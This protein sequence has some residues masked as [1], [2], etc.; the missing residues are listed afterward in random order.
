MTEL[1]PDSPSPPPQTRLTLV[2]TVHRDPQGRAKLLRLLEELRPDL[3]TLEMSP[4]ALHYRQLHSRHLG[5]RLERILER[6]ARERGEDRRSVAGHP[7]VADILSLLELPFEYQACAAWAEQSGTPLRLIDLGEISVAK[8]KRVETELI[9]YRNLRVLVGL[10]EGA[11]KTSGEGLGFARL[12]LGERL[13]EA[14]RQA[15]LE[16]HRGEEG[17]GQRDK[18]MEG[19]IRELLRSRPGGH[20]VHVGGWLHLVADRRAE[21]LYSRLADLAPQRLLL[22]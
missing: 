10:P 16:R 17:I 11:E 21:T 12:L 6:L 15:F 3:L 18:W 1:N 20:L 22:G 5:L 8:L 14:V 9:T 7:A 2:G 19:K 13:D 4:A